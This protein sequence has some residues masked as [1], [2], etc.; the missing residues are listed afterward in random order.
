MIERWP[1]G[2]AAAS[3][4][5]G[6]LVRVAGEIERHPWWQARARL[7]LALLARHGVAPPASVLDAGCGWGVT[8]SA[9]ERHRFAA[10]GLDVSPDA[11]DR[12]DRPA[13]RLILADLTQPLPAGHPT[14]DAVLALDVIEHLDD[15]RAAVARVA[16]LAR[17][18]GLVMLSV[19]ALQHLY[20]E[21]DE[22]QGHRRRYDE[23]ALRA[24]CAGSLLEIERVLWWGR[25]FV[26]L[27]R[28][29]R[30]TPKGRPGEAPD[31]VYERYTRAPRPPASWALDAVAGV[32]NMFTLR[33]WTSRGTSLFAVARR[34][35]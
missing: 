19:P 30:R 33:E 4:D 31:V 14:F 17:P 9:L 32:E 11:L 25:S 27:L 13:R 7:T 16:A 24:A 22:V 28:W 8:L 35:S 20:S 29:Q 12:L 6:M 10:A 3:M 23:A 34:R 5:A 26:P 1:G 2:P 21:F 15:D 18:G